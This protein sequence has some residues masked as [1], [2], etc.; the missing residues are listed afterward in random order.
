MENRNWLYRLSFIIN[1]LRVS[2]HST[3]NE[4]NDYIQWRFECKNIKTDGKISKRQFQRNVNEI[5]EL[6]HVD[7]KCDKSNRYYISSD[8]QHKES[9]INMRMQ[10][11]LDLINVLDTDKHLLSCMLFEDR[12]KLGTQYIYGFLHA[13]KNNLVIKFYHQAHFHKEAIEREVEPYALKE[14]KGRW[15]VLAKDS[16]DSRLK[17]FAL[18]RI[19]DIELT[20][21]KYTVPQG[22]N[23]QKYFENCYGVS[24]TDNASVETVVLSFDSVQGNYI[25]TYPIHESQ[26]ELENSEGEYRISLDVY[27]NHELIMEIL[28]YGESVEVMQPTHLAETI[29]ST[30]LNTVK[31]Y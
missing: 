27:I 7:I 12:C 13:I 8:D 6:F 17:T 29:K 11:A 24:I 16:C 19:T 5:R 10:E 25:R 28:S 15:Y 21:K 14:F 2:N 31:Y 30:L 23:P 26:K 22:F 3:F 9:P 18:D 4:L 1:K 20:K